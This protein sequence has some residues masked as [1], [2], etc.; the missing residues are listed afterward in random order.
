MHSFKETENA[1]CAIKEHDLPKGHWRRV[2]DP[3]ARVS[4]IVSYIEMTKSRN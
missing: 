2:I 3:D 1:S 4:L